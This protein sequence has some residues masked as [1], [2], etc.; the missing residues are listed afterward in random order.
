MLLTINGCLL[1]NSAISFQREKQRT[2]ALKLYP[3][4]RGESYLKL[5]SVDLL[6]RLPIYSSCFFESE[7]TKIGCKLVNFKNFTWLLCR[8]LS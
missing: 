6:G 3:I 2:F 4:R 5:F 7:F 8:L 1:L